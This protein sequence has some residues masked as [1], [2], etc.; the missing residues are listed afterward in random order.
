MQGYGLRRVVE[1][2]EPPRERP[3]FFETWRAQP[4]GPSLTAHLV[5]VVRGGHK[6]I[7]DRIPGSFGPH[8][9]PV[10]DFVL[11]ASPISVSAH[12]RALHHPGVEDVVMLA[13]RYGTGELV[14]LALSRVHPRKERL[15]TFVGTDKL[16]EFDD[17]AKQ[18]LRIVSRAD[19]TAPGFSDFS[20]FLTRTDGDV[21]IPRIEMTEPL[22][23]QLDDFL[24][25]IRE[26]R[27]PRADLASGLRVL[28]VLDAAQ[29]SLERDGAVT[30]VG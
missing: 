27:S 8:D 1:G 14:N 30:P 18:R 26:Q 16:V 24:G 11:G 19:T 17:V 10:L 22:R 5:G 25:C 2:G 6:V 29:R 23:A 3:V 13:L 7:H 28:A 20:E 12:G 4:G 9:R 15:L 21:H